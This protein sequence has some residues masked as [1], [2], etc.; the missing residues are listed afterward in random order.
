MSEIP[1]SLSEAYPQAVM[2]EVM[3]ITPRRIQQLAKEGI[4]RKDPGG[5]YPFART[6]SEYLDFLRGNAKNAGQ[7]IDFNAEKARKTKAEADIA[8]IAAA[9]AKG[10]VVDL[11][12]V[13]RNLE[14]VFA[15]VK[16]NMRNVPQRVAPRIIGET[17]EHRIKSAILDEI[18]QAMESMAEEIDWESA[19]EDEDAEIEIQQ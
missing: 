17:E 16:S 3:G 15:E 9:K 19:M 2:C 6:I 10:E 8:E 1:E 11:K 12:D 7:A 5:K 18:D 13:E 4:I 14:F